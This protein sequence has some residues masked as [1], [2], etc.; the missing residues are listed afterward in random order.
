MSTL[1][2]QVLSEFLARVAASAQVSQATVEGLADL[3]SAGKLPRPDDVAR[4]YADGIKDS[5]A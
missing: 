3:L 2:Q 1:D 4:L 5:R